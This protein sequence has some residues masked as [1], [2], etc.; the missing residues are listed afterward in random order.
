MKYIE[1]KTFYK[2][3]EK[4][5]KEILNI[6][7][8]EL[9]DLYADVSAYGENH[10]A[11]IKDLDKKEVI[12]IDKGYDYYVPLLTEGQIRTMIENI[13]KSKIEVVYVSK[14][15][16]PN[17]KSYYRIERMT[18]LDGDINNNIWISKTEDLLVA[19]WETLVKILSKK[20]E[21]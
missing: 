4:I 21:G 14:E 7:K 11:V 16:V 18:F 9:G 13:I 19:Y 20:I 12:E 17:E 3:N 2:L 10:I 8:P 1:V 5:R 15:G 6:W